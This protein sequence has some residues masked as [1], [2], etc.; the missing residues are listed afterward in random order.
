MTAYETYKATWA[1]KSTS[2]V[3]KELSSMRKYVQKHTAAY[4]WHGAGM[5][6]P[7]VCADGDKITALREILA[8][9][10]EVRV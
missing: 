10:G 2:K 5:T 8:E 3:L 9:R 1:E 6:P 4:A 7:G